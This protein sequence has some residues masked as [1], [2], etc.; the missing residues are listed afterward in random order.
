[1]FQFKRMAFGLRN[2][3]ASFQRLTDLIMPPEWSPYVRKYVDDFI[4]F[5]KT[6]EQHLVWI[7]R[8]IDKRVE[9]NL[10]INA[11]KSEFLC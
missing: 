5:T 9:A 10:T 11:E 2:G 4:I 3:P 8:V 7:E 1:M 6:L